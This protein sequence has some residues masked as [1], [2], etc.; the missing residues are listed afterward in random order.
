MIAYFNNL[1]LA[2]LFPA[3]E[4]VQTANSEGLKVSHIGNTILKTLIHLIKLISI[5]YVP[6]LS[7]SLLTVQIKFVLTTTIG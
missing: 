1:S 2:T 3:N 6:K 4:T 7:Q 5:F